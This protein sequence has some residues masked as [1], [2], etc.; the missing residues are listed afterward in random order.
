MGRVGCVKCG[1]TFA[2]DKEL[3]EHRAADH[4]TWVEAEPIEP[5]ARSDHPDADWFS[6]V[7]R[8]HPAFRDDRAWHSKRRRRS[9]RGGLLRRIF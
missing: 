2:G 6:W 1:R 9:W 5:P 7:D 3:A 4:P 8:S